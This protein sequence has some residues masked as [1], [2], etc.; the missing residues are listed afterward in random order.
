MI[1]SYV[2]SPIPFYV[3]INRTDWKQ[4]S[5][6][7]FE[8]YRNPV[9]AEADFSISLLNGI[10]IRVDGDPGAVSSAFLLPWG[11]GDTIILDAGAFGVAPT[12][13]AGIFSIYL[14]P[15]VLSAPGVAL[16]THYYLIVEAGSGSFGSECVYAFDGTD[17]DYPRDCN[18]DRKTYFKVSWSSP[19]L[20]KGGGALETGGY[21]LYLE[22]EVG[23]PEWSPTESGDEDAEGQE[24]VDY[25]RIRKRMSITFDGTQYIADA[26]VHT[27]LFDVR[28]IEFDDGLIWNFRDPK[29]SVAW[30][31]TDCSKFGF[32]EFS[33]EIDGLARFGCS[34]DCE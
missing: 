21:M 10:D 27:L 24:V 30:N 17:T 1:D 32:I 25:Q 13:D 33:F 26:L 3:S 6:Q 23:R 34:A 22:G 19:C 11:G 29:V 15:S 31:D 16:N 14:Q 18:D 8:P 2:P 7:A 28:T 12:A 4:K 5:C 9:L 20:I